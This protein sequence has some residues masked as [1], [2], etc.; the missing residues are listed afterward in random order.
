MDAQW[1]ERFTSVYEELGGLGER[2]LGN[3]SVNYGVTRRENFVF[4]NVL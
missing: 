2:V 1:K 4:K 3:D